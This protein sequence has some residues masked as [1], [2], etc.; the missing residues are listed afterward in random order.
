MKTVQ[1]A[2]KSKILVLME[3]GD[4]KRWGTFE[5]NVLAFISSVGVAKNALPLMGRRGCTGSGNNVCV[6][7]IE[8]L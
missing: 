7:G 3:R 8:I 5:I 4:S 2:S 6:C 1:L